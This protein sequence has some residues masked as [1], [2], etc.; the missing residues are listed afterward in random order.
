MTILTRKVWDVVLQ[1][2]RFYNKT[3]YSY[4]KRLIKW[5]TSA[6]SVFDHIG[7]LEFIQSLKL[8]KQKSEVNFV[9]KIFG[10][11]GIKLNEFELRHFQNERAE[12]P[13]ARAS[14]QKKAAL[15]SDIDIQDMISHSE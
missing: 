15:A 8:A 7:Y 14:V 2:E 3:E 11:A 4:A 6:N 12:G 9:V 5:T 10:C 1:N 13:M